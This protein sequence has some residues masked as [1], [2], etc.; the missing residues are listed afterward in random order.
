MSPK[1]L[2]RCC[3]SIAC[4]D[5]VCIGLLS[6]FLN[7]GIRSSFRETADSFAT[8][9]MPR[10]TLSRGINRIYTEQHDFFHSAYNCWGSPVKPAYSLPT[11]A[12]KSVLRVR[13]GVGGGQ[14]EAKGKEIRKKLR[15]NPLTYRSGM[16]YNRGNDSARA[17]EF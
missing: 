16:D 9:Y 14:K 13:G 6:G 3:I 7:P 5:D 1:D 12:G 2:S 17:G 10:A 4:V 15:G 11:P 8:L